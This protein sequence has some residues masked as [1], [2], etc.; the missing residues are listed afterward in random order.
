MCYPTTFTDTTCVETDVSNRVEDNIGCSNAPDEM[1]VNPPPILLGSRLRNN[2]STDDETLR[3]LGKK[4]LVTAEVQRQRAY[5][6]YL[7]VK[8]TDEFKQRLKIAKQQYY[9]NNKSD[10]RERERHKYLNDTEYHETVREKARLKYKD[11]TADRIPQ[12]RG[13]KPKPVD[14]N[15]V[16][17]PKPRGRPRKQ[18]ESNVYNSE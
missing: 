1:L 11:K 12:K 4:Y 3:N 17:I 14:V 9:Q 6:Y 2:D 18:V 5:S 10:I 13:R 7:K 8:D 16:S 15:A